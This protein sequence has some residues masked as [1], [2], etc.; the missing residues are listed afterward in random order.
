MHEMIYMMWK[1]YMPSD[2]YKYICKEENFVYV[3]GKNIQRWL[4]LFGNSLRLTK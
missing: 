4:K 2:F 3:N 1:E